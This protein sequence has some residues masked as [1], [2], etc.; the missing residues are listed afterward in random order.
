MGGIR[1]GP[2]ERLHGR[3]TGVHARQA[4]QLPGRRR[5]GSDR[6]D[7]LGRRIDGGLRPRQRQ[8][9]RWLERQPVGESRRRRA[10]DLGRPHGDTRRDLEGDGRKQSRAVSR[11]TLRPAG[12]RRTDLPGARVA[13]AAGRGGR[14][15]RSSI[16]SSLG[17]EQQPCMVARRH[18]DRVR[19]QPDRSQLHR[20]VRRGDADGEIH[21]AGRRLRHEPDVVGR[22]QAD[23]LRAPA[24]HALWPAVA[25]GQWRTRSAGRPRL[26]RHGRNRARRRRTWGWRCAAAAAPGRRARPKAPATCRR[27]HDRCRA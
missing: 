13:G 16:H 11:R 4:Q 15:R 12:S 20:R 27:P 26:S 1:Q 23:Y 2:T 5:R 8:E 7:D 18:Q 6:R 24:G 21:G 22:Q 19:Q 25:R 9:P 3:R 10:G 17:H 14:P